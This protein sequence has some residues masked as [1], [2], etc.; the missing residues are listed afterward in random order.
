VTA[1]HILGPFQLDC[2]A[3]LLLRGREPVA[4][5]KRAVAVLRVLVEQAGGAVSKEA[6]IGAAWPGLTV[7]ENNLVVQIAALRRALGDEPGGE[8]WIETLPRRG[9]RFVGPA[10][11]AKAGQ[12]TI[13]G[14]PKAVKSLAATDA[15][16][17]RLPLQPS[18]AVLPFQNMSGNPEQDYFADGMVEEILTALSRFR[19]LFVIA[20]NSSFAY[21]GPSVDVKRVGRELGVRYVLEGSVRRSDNRVRITAQLIDALNGAHLWAD[22]FDGTLGDVF[23]LQ[24]HVAARVVG[25]IEPRLTR[26]ERDRAKR[27]PAAD[28][29]AYDYYL[30]ALANGY[31]MTRGESDEVLRLARKAIEL[32]PDFASAYGI[33]AWFHTRRAV[34]KWTDDGVHERGEALKMARRAAELGKEDAFCLSFAGYAFTFAG[35]EIEHGAALADRA[36]ELNPNLAL[37]W[38]I[39]GWLRLVLGQPD[40]AIERM[41]R[42]M[43]LS[44]LDPFMRQWQSATAIAHFLSDRYDEALSWAVQALR[45]DPDFAT[46]WRIAAACHALAGHA[47]EARAACARLQQLEPAL[48]IGNFREVIAPYRRPSDLAKWEVGLRMAGLPE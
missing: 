26:V 19:S 22:R 10:Q 38:G 12:E 43:R 8:R 36:V 28:L 25:E 4:L 34:N 1:T 40:I 21:K 11:I 42:S 23:D 30:R 6:L 29:D 13:A 17:L 46:P 5:G 27:K 20:R 14:A 48:R 33:A 2:E 47:E 32:D 41:G 45:P 39:S 31:L 18:I 7:E 3:Q 37:A 9:Y 16:S 24:D 35:R 15:P 44:P